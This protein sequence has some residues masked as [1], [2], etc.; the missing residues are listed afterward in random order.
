[1]GWTRKSLFDWVEQREVE[2]DSGKG[3]QSL[4]SAAAKIITKV[5]P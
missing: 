1:V 4:G 2:R 5:K 3:W